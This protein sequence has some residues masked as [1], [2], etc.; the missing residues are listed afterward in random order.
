[1]HSDIHL[2]DVVALLEDLPVKHFETGQPLLLRRGQIG[3][4]VMAYDGRTFE[5]EFAGPDGHAYALLPIA[6]SKLMVLRIRPRTQ[7]RSWCAN[8]RI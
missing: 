7:R 6:V 1:M 2:H 3:T 8:R 4:V 5:V